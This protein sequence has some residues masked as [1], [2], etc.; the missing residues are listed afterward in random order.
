M[1]IEK[2]H[3]QGLSS[4]FDYGEPSQHASRISLWR[5]REQAVGDITNNS[6]IL[7]GQGI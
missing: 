1:Y 5:H 6:A 7:S 4:C 2:P 3:P